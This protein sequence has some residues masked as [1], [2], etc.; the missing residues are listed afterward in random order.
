MAEQMGSLQNSHDFLP[1]IH[2]YCDTRRA[3]YKYGLLRS[4]FHVE[5]ANSSIVFE[6]EPSDEMAMSVSA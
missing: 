5:I 6:G 4:H 3:S 1:V 2:G